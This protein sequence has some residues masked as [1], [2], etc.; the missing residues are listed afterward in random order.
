MGPLYRTEVSARDGEDARLR[1]GAGTAEG[2]LPTGGVDVVAALAP[3]EGRELLRA[4]PLLELEH[5]PLV[6]RG[7]GAPGD[8][9]HRDEVHLHRNTS[10]ELHQ[11]IGGP[12]VVVHPADERVLDGDPAPA[13]E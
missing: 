1:A 3:D 2:Q 12:E 8:R 10:E 11:P 7:V 9:I 6:R 13:R 5:P 4:E